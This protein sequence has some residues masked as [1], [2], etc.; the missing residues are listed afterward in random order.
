MYVHDNNVLVTANSIMSQF[1]H[2]AGPVRCRGPSAPPAHP[3]V[4]LHLGGGFG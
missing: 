1:A 2:N 4:V 3:A